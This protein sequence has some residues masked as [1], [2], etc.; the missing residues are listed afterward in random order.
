MNSVFWAHRLRCSCCRNL[1]GQVMLAEPCL[2]SEF[3]YNE[4]EQCITNGV[5]QLRQV[6]L[7]F[8]WQVGRRDPDGQLRYGAAAMSWALWVERWWWKRQREETGSV[9]GRKAWRV[10]NRKRFHSNSKRLPM[11]VNRAR[12]HRK[13]RLR[14][15]M[16][17]HTRDVDQDVPLQS[18]QYEAKT[19]VVLV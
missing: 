12:V 13:Y 17:F 3:Q 18:K 9:H 16:I 14:L 6:C 11:R 5:G 19:P 7:S 4:C 15:M 1:Q 8:D 2:R 10:D